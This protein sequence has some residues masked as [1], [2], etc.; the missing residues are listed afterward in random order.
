REVE[1]GRAG[2]QHRDEITEALVLQ[3][4]VSSSR[5]EDHCREVCNEAGARGFSACGLRKASMTRLA[6][7]GCSVHEIQAFSGHKTLSEIAHY[8]SSVEQAALARKAMAKTPTKLSKNAKM[9]AKTTAE[10]LDGGNFWRINSLFA[11]PGDPLDRRSRPG[12]L[13][14]TCRRFARSLRRR[15]QNDLA[16]LVLLRHKR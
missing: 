4:L 2:R 10:N 15:R 1:Q 5:R 13:G 9:R 12:N 7:A 14:R 6:K 16:C 8:T 11:P 3:L